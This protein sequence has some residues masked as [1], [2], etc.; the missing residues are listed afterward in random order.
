MELPQTIRQ[1]A[2][3]FL[4][5][6]FWIAVFAQFILR[7]REKQEIKTTVK[8]PNC[9]QPNLEVDISEISVGADPDNYFAR[10]SILKN[11][12]GGILALMLAY[13]FFTQFIILV[14]DLITGSDA[15]G[16]Q[17][18]NLIAQVGFPGSMLVLGL[19]FL[20]TGAL[21][22]FQYFQKKEKNILLTCND[23]ESVF[24]GVGPLSQQVASG[25][26]KL[27]GEIEDIPLKIIK[28]SISA[29][30]DTSQS[31]GDVKINLE[32]CKKCGSLIE[33]SELTCPNCGHT[34]WGVIAVLA[35]ICLLAVGFVLY[36]IVN[37]KG[38]GFIFWVSAVL[39]VLF[40][41]AA[42]HSVVKAIQGRS[43]TPPSQEE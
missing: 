36:R 25:D 11:I 20:G 10:I 3:Y 17:S 7:L 35:V 28:G 33:T 39:G 27:A 34:Q 24:S 1:F 30:K 4:A 21:A 42:V 32:P 38:S 18:D 22:I 26:S 43:R 14:K 15:T 41:G 31:D 8:C 9:G 6:I 16:I 12:G 40:F 37:D 19:S 13:L 29:P 2:G 23:C 5:G